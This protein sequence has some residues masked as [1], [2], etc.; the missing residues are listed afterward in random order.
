MRFDRV[1]IIVAIIWYTL[2]AYFSIGY[3]HADEH[4]QIVE[5]AGIIDGTNTPKDLAWEYRAQIR[6]AVQPVICNL[7]FQTCNYFSITDPYD[8]AF[9]LRLI[10]GLLSVIIISFF[11]NSFKGIIQGKTWKLFLVLS[12]FTWF[13]PFLN[14][15]FS[16]E[17]WSG[18]SFLLALS[19]VIRNKNSYRTYFILGCLLGLSFLFR[20]QIAFAGL[21][22]F[23]WLIFIKKETVAKIILMLTAGLLIA[24]IGVFIDSWFYGNWTFTFWNYFNENLIIGKVSEFGTSPW[25]YYFFYI[26][27]YSFFPFGILIIV[28]LLFLV[29][30]KSNSIFIWII[31]PFIIIH[32]F[33]SHKELRF[34]FPLVNLI[35][36]VFILALQEFRSI[37]WMRT[38]N[39]LIKGMFIL[40]MIV[41]MI[42]VIVASIKPAGTS[43]IRIA[44]KIYKMDRDKPTDLYYLNNSNPFLPWGLRTNFYAPGNLMNKELGIN[45]Q[46][47]IP[48]ADKGRQNVLVIKTRDAQNIEIRNF[49][50]S[51]KMTEKCKSI[52]EFLIPFLKIYG[53]RTDDI[54]ILYS[55]K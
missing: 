35:P 46:I 31:L 39:P 36:I 40:I 26:F 38:D 12:Y 53:Y 9:V 11:T 23:L 5:F 29:F 44:E 52:Q 55:D 6:P 54:L 18:I 42:A 16:S 15:R 50:R 28:A 27:R 7:I 21:G 25:Y 34:L 48:S 49:I 4:Y 37:K 32:S 20:F 8:K 43:G 19:F 47:I 41:N 45:K 22:L 2:T 13:L 51:M 33:I 3:F 14:V 30:R 10:T 17:T 1:I 24:L